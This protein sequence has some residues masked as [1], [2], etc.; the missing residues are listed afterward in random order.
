[1][2]KN[3]KLIAILASVVVVIVAV[4]LIITAMKSARKTELAPHAEDDGKKMIESIRAESKTEEN[5]VKVESKAESKA[6]VESKTEVPKADSKDVP[7]GIMMEDPYGMYIVTEEWLKKNGG[8][9][10][11]R[12]GK[13]YAFGGVIMG[14]VADDYDI[15]YEI[16]GGRSYQ[17]SRLYI[18]EENKHNTLP[19]NAV[20]EMSISCGDFPIF[21]VSRNETVR[22]YSKSTV[23][24]VNFKKATFYGYTLAAWVSNRVYKPIVDHIMAADKGIVGASNP[25]VCDKNDQPVADVYN[26]EYGKEYKYIWYK[27]TE[28]H[29][30]NLLADSRAYIVSK[31]KC[32][33]KV[34]LTKYGYATLDFSSLTPGTYARELVTVFEVTD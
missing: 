28:Y 10:V 27:G 9:A 30:M 7:E 13:L 17:F 24:N 31:E 6:E 12:N 11:E 18:G 22:F 25:G 33:V 20:G 15:G 2:N 19:T 34:E 5:K 14:D 21:K 16:G 3:K 1:M 8:Y 32:S 26:L 29:E 23:S 4:I